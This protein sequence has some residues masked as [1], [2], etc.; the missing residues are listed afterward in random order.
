MKTFDVGVE[1]GREIAGKLEGTLGRG[2]AT[3]GCQDCPDGHR[4]TP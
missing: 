3:A 4:C 2:T 1:A